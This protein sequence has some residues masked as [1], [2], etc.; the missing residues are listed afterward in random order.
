MIVKGTKV[1]ILNLKDKRKGKVV[2][3]FRHGSLEYF[4]VLYQNRNGDTFIATT[5]KNNLEVIR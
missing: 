3:I 4:R 5:T 2:E 1:K